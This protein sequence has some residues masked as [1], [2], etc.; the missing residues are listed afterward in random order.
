MKLFKNVI[1]KTL[2]ESGIVL[3]GDR[4]FDITVRNDDFYRRV[5]LYGSLGLGESYMDGWWECEH[6]D[7]LVNRLFISN[8]IKKS[9]F[10][11]TFNALHAKFVNRQN[12]TESR[13]V[14]ELHYNLDTEL[15]R[16]M[17]GETMAYTCAYWKGQ[18][19]L[20][21]AQ[22]NKYEL[23]CKKI[24]LKKSD[25]VL[26]LGCGF[27]GLARYMAEQYG[28]SVTGVNISGQQLDF[29]RE[30]CSGLPVDFHLCDYR[31]VSTYNPEGRLFDKIVSIGLCEHIGP[32]NY[33][34]WTRIVH[35]QLKEGGLF[36][37]HT[38]GI[39]TTKNHC[40]PWYDKYI[41]P[42][43]TLPS[44]KQ[45]G[46]AFEGLFVME[47]WHNFGF[48]YNVTLD[49]W[50]KNFDAYWKNNIEDSRGG[51]T[52]DRLRFYRMW[53]FYLLAG[54]GTFKSR[55]IQLWQIVL[56]KGNIPMTYYPVR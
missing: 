48:D 45:L 28:C 19:N 15:Y 2:D 3:N 49:E 13:A 40:D 36:L 6:L 10:I 53:R 27:G 32:K 35:D 52:P 55:H 8:T 24:D 1:E 46:N 7:E 43:G 51:V 23:I 16:H 11:D 12:K 44:I 42:N 29:A 37:L 14:A 54:R 9:Y 20:N 56:S 41:F 50:W 30:F 22:L 18:M 5:V 33:M 39:N 4:P 17:L 38:I 21:D 26:D 34:S 25:R 31:D 47:D